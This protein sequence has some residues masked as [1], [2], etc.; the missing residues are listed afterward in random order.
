[1]P[2]YLRKSHRHTK[3]NWSKAQ[4]HYARDRR[5]RSCSPR[6]QNDLSGTD[7]KAGAQQSD[8]IIFGPK[9]KH[10]AFV[11]EEELKC[12]IEDRVGTPHPSDVRSDEDMTPQMNME[13]FE[14]GG[15][16][17]T[18]EAGA[19]SFFPETIR[20]VTSYPVELM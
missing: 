10:S 4:A 17:S 7:F 5:L 6:D 18:Y 19:K 20:G 13:E 14:M 8:Q 12:Q 11:I 16:V 9:R 2:A 3:I 15:K 1:M